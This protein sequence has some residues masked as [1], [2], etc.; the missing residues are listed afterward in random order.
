MYV[1]ANLQ[2]C[3]SAPCMLLFICKAKLKLVGSQNLHVVRKLC[4]SLV[5]IALA[6]LPAFSS[7]VQVLRAMQASYEQAFYL[8]IEGAVEKNGNVLDLPKI[9]GKWDESLT[10]TMPDG[11]KQLIW[12]TNPPATDPTRCPLIAFDQEHIQCLHIAQPPSMLDVQANFKFE[13]LYIACSHL[14]ILF[15]S[16]HA[17]IIGV[18]G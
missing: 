17:G 9:E 14:P 3:R 5:V 7:A 8:Q 4:G 1:L 13:N 12:K 15:K 16:C 11:S 18:P 2:M 10:A 6:C